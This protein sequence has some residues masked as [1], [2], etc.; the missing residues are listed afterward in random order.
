[1][2]GY[3]YSSC[4]IQRL[5]YAQVG[6]FRDQY[7]RPYHFHAD[8]SMEK[9]LIDV[10]EQGHQITAKDV[11]G[12]HGSLMRQSGTTEGVAEIVNGWNTNRYNFIL[13]VLATD[14]M[15]MNYLWRISGYTE[16]CDT[17][18]G[19][20][21]DPNMRFY[22]S[23]ETHAKIINSSSALGMR[24]NLSIGYTGQQLHNSQFGNG[25]P[26]Y[27]ITPSSTVMSMQNQGMASQ[28]G[29]AFEDHTN[30][31]SGL[32]R[33]NQH[34]NN[35]G[36]EMAAGLIKTYV[37][38]ARAS[39]GSEEDHF[40]V[41]ESDLLRSI[42]TSYSQT[43]MHI[44]NPFV[45]FLNGRRNT[46]SMMGANGS[47]NSFTA[48]DLLA[49]DNSYQQRMQEVPSM[50][51][52]SFRNSSDDSGGGDVGS[53]FS[54]SLAHAVVAAVNSFGFGF[55]HFSASN[56]TLVTG[57]CDIRPMRMEMIDKSFDNRQPTIGFASY[58]TNNILFALSNANS[59]GYSVE[60]MCIPEMY[61]EILLSIEFGQEQRFVYPT[62]GSALYAPVLTRDYK[63]LTTAASSFQTLC[64][65]VVQI[66]AER[67]VGGVGGRNPGF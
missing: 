42:S 15:G 51:D 59:F 13:E 1:M 41:V 21:F 53:V 47:S 52:I 3:S 20:H 24:K 8:S 32:S 36:N 28:F 49:F 63:N 45:E 4:G 31:V 35:I 62:Y 66:T 64:D 12:E 33:R 43:E 17:S 10:T 54:V 34:R 39:F 2:N 44:K 6:T 61:T 27:S 7:V 50:G 55:A 23:S 37:G 5:L 57:E 38:E 65:N 16:H 25:S 40:G 19:G 18:F 56:R 58:M 14:Q 26:I 60:V 46:V 48:S 67:S 22:I 9:R 29:G 30:V 11:V